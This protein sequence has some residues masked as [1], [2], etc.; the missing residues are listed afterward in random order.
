M[1]MPLEFVVSPTAVQLVA[2]TQDTALRLAPSR[3]TTGTT[4]QRAPF[5]DSM[6]WVEAPPAPELYPTATHTVPEVHDTPNSTLPVAEGLGTSAQRVPFHDS[7]SA[8]GRS[9]T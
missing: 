5:H 9:L 7:I 2:V 4:D 8:D 6:S 1:S 3:S